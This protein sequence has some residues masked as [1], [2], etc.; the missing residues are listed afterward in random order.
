MSHTQITEYDDKTPRLT[1]CKYAAEMLSYQLDPGSIDLDLG[2]EKTAWRTCFINLWLTLKKS[3]RGWNNFLYLK[4]FSGCYNFSLCRKNLADVLD[5][6]GSYI[7]IEYPFGS[8]L[9]ARY[10]YIYG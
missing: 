10:I 6:L 2:I 1:I 5:S 7:V 9:D 8:L 4:R 3:E